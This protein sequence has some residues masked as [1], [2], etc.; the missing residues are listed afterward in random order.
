MRSS[1]EFKTIKLSVPLLSI[2]LPAFTSCAWFQKH[3]PSIDCAALATVADAPQLA[4]IVEACMGIAVSQAAVIPCVEGAVASKWTNDVI[5]CFTHAAQGA[6]SCP[7]FDAAKTIHDAEQPTPLL[8]TTGAPY[9]SYTANGTQQSFAISSPVCVVGQFAIPSVHNFVVL[10]NSAYAVA[11]QAYEQQKGNP[12]GLLCDV[13]VLYFPYIGFRLV[14]TGSGLSQ[15]IGT[16]GGVAVD[17]KG[18]QIAWSINPNMYLG[19]VA[20]WNSFAGDKTITQTFA[21]TLMH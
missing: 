18:M 9:L 7:L 16:A 3:E 13:N 5:G 19:E 21:A 10:N 12:F 14:D 4:G 15:Q 17:L 11:Y 20:N 6:A 8:K 1:K 2:L